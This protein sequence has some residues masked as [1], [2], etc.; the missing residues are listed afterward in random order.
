[1]ENKMKSKKIT[2][3]NQIRDI[4]G[5][6]KNNLT[7]FTQE[8]VFKISNAI[9][10]NDFHQKTA[11]GFVVPK[12]K[13]QKTV[14]THPLSSNLK[15]IVSALKEASRLSLVDVI[16][17][18]D[19]GILSQTKSISIDNNVVTIKLKQFFQVLYSFTLFL[20]RL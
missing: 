9:M 5:I 15:A 8:E 19:E 10:K 14:Q 11:F 17:G 3:S 20:Q 12:W 7:Y 1:M 16:K 4:L 13:D 18:I 2:L 6:K